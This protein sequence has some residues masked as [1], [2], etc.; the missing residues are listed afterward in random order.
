MCIAKIMNGGVVDT[1]YLDFAKAFDT[2]RHRRLIHKLE[3]YGVSGNKTKLDKSI[4]ERTQSSCEGERSGFRVGSVLGPILFVVYINDLPEAIT[5]DTFLFADDTKILR[6]ITSGQD[7]LTLLSDIDKVNEWSEKWLLKFNTEKCHVLALGKFENIV[8]TPLQLYDDEL[9]HVFKEV[10]LGVTV[11]AELMFQEHISAKIKKA[12]SIVGLIRRSFS[13]L[14]CHLFNKVYITFVRPHLEYA[15]AIRAP[16][17]K[18]H[19]HMIEIVQI[20]AP[21]VVDVSATQKD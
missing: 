2:V 14:N 18:K 8:Y 19:T 15:Q 16:H 17:L 10:N 12:N 3:S 7:A 5:S 4:P 9:E 13:F 21:K 6:Q 11:D 1:I 20:P